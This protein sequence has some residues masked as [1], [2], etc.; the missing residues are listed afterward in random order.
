MAT[1]AFCG[2][3]DGTVQEINLCNDCI[4]FLFN[5]IQAGGKDQK[6]AISKIESLSILNLMENSPLK[7]YWDLQ[8]LIQPGEKARLDRGLSKE[9]KP[10][11]IEYSSEIGLFVGGSGEIYETSLQKCQCFDYQARNL[12]CKHMFRLASEIE[13]RGE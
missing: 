1:C 4:R 2:S 6:T 12:P 8:S 5:Q 7:R 9:C 10:I 3:S 13:N 11:R